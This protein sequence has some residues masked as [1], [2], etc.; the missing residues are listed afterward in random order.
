MKSLCYLHLMPHI[1]YTFLL[2]THTCTHT[3]YLLGHTADPQGDVCHW[4][5]LYGIVIQLHILF[6]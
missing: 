3:L 5:T 4:L 6:A 1:S 2:H